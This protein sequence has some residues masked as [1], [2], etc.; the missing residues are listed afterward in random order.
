LDDGDGYGAEEVEL[1]NAL[2]KELEDA[3]GQ[4]GEAEV[5]E[6]HEMD[7]AENT[8]GVA[9][10]DA[11]DVG[12]EDLEAESSD[13]DEEDLDE[14]EA[15]EDDVEMGDDANAA[16]AQQPPHQPEVMVH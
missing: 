13:D 9:D 14:E 1:E 12:S 3:E 16:A 5:G 8:A 7:G 4:N 11:S 2:I 15:G 6:D 10:D